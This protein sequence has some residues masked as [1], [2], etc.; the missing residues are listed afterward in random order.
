MV[1]LYAIAFFVLVGFISDLI[2][3]NKSNER[4]KNVVTYF[5]KSSAKE[6]Q[7]EQEASFID[8]L[9]KRTD[10]GELGKKFLQKQEEWKELNKTLIN[11]DTHRRCKLCHHKM[12]LKINT[13]TGGRFLACSRYP[14]CKYTENYHGK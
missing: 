1:I 7:I 2:E 12:L 5:N 9:L 13:N 4:M 14:Y 8:S 11:L 10:I 3:K 6:F